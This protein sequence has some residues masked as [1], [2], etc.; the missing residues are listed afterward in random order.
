MTYL[1]VLIAAL[2][3]CSMRRDSREAQ[4]LRVQS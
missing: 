2:M 4:M 1:P 3:T